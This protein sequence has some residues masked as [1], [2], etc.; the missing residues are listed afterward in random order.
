MMYETLPRLSETGTLE[1]QCFRLEE[2]HRQTR[3]SAV[4]QVGAHEHW[5]LAKPD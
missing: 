2:E 4:L 3:G 5:E 1:I